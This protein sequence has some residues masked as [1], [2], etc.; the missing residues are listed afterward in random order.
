MMGW[1][2]KTFYRVSPAV[3][4]FN[5]FIKIFSNNVL[6]FDNTLNYKSAQIIKICYLY[7]TTRLFEHIF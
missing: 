5:S 7:F 6:P 4:Q 2:F 3:E 1:D